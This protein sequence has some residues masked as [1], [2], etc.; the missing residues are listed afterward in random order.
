[1]KEAKKKLLAIFASAHLVT[2]SYLWIV[3]LVIFFSS[4][5]KYVA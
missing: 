5:D 3:P 1:M 4:L 2:L